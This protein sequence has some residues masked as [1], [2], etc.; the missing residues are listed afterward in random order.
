[1]FWFFPCVCMKRTK[2]CTCHSVF[3]FFF[4]FSSLFLDKLA[5]VFCG[6]TTVLLSMT[7]MTKIGLVFFFFFSFSTRFSTDC[8]KLFNKRFMINYQGSVW[9]RSDSFLG[10]T[11][12]SFYRKCSWSCYSR[13][14]WHMARLKHR[15][16]HSQHLKKHQKQPETRSKLAS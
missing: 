7:R 13:R 4:S 14:V 9:R 16:Q 8:L 5:K 6:G 1:M 3:F 12:K 10:H 15:N 2:L 11:K